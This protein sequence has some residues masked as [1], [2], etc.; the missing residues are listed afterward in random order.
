MRDFKRYQRPAPRN[1]IPDA[2]D[3]LSSEIVDEE[4][5]NWQLY[6]DYDGDDDDRPAKG[7][8]ENDACYLRQIAA[9]S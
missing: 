1:P 7:S 2:L 8:A 5:V 3:E 9:Y 6:D 4:A